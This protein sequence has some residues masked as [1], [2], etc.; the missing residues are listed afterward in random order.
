M[1]HQETDWLWKTTVLCYCWVCWCC[2]PGWRYGLFRWWYHMSWRFR[3][4]IRFRC[5]FYYDWK[6]VCRY[7]WGRRRNHWKVCNQWWIWYDF[8]TPTYWKERV[9]KVLWYEF[10]SGTGEIWKWKTKLSC[11]RRSCYTDTLYWTDSRYYWRTTW[12]VKKYN[13]IYW[14][15][16]TKGYSQT[17]CVL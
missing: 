13:D 1:S 10:N 8:W 7:R 14:C 16:K 4:G 9:Q 2:S 3:K 15:Q 11:E 12:W 5:W 6:S 17:V